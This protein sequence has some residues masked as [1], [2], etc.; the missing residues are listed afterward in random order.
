MAA[1]AAATLTAAGTPWE[2]V[3]D[4]LPGAT[5][6]LGPDANNAETDQGVEI[7]V[8]GGYIYIVTNHDVT[9]RVFSILGDLI[10]DG[11]LKPGVYRMPMKARGIYIVK[12]GMA[13]LRVTL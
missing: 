1:L 12:A 6:H 3:N 8:R 10:G 2:Q 5:L 9:A 13:T 4:S 11:Q 7:F